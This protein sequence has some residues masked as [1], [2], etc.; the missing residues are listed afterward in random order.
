M[1]FHNI[2]LSEDGFSGPPSGPPPRTGWHPISGLCEPVRVAMPSGSI[3]L[4]RG[5]VRWLG[6]GSEDHGRGRSRRI[7]R[8]LTRSLAARLCRG[9]CPQASDRWLTRRPVAYPHAL[10]SASAAAP[11][12]TAPRI[13][14]GNRSHAESEALKADRSPGTGVPRRDQ[15]LLDRLCL[16]APESIFG[17]RSRSRSSSGSMA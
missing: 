8:H 14:Q 12:P 15:S 5:R 3:S 10:T 7:R 1:S 4:G 16:S 2:N 17:F 13:P 9:P 6:V 11:D